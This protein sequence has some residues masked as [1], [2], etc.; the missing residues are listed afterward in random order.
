MSCGRHLHPNSSLTRGVFLLI[1]PVSLQPFLGTH[2]S[3]VPSQP[4]TLPLAT[5]H[6]SLRG[7]SVALVKPTST[8]PLPS[9]EGPPLP[10]SSYNDSAPLSLLSSLGHDT[11]C[12]LLPLPQVHAHTSICFREFHPKVLPASKFQTRYC[13]STSAWEVGSLGPFYR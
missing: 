5:V 2:L 9:G 13:L 12:L 1:C 8:L 4:L 3:P 11:H 6:S 10:C 7:C